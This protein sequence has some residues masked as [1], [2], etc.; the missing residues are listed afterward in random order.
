MA[1]RSASCD[2][3][4]PP[5]APSVR[6][7]VRS[8]AVDSFAE[9]RADGTLFRALVPGDV[10]ELVG[11]MLQAPRWMLFGLDC[12]TNSETAL[13]FDLGGAEQCWR[14]IGSPG[15]RLCA[16]TTHCGEVVACAEAFDSLLLYRFNDRGDAFGSFAYDVPVEW[17][18]DLC[19]VGNT[20]MA[21]CPSDEERSIGKFTADYKL[22]S[23]TKD[24]R[25]GVFT[26][27]VFEADN[28]LVV[29]GG[30]TASPNHNTRL[31]MRY[32][33]L[34][35]RWSM[36]PDMNHARSQFGC[37]TCTDR[38]TLYAVAG[39][40]ETD[41]TIKHSPA[42]ERLDLRTTAWQQ[43]APLHWAYGMIHMCQF[44]EHT[45]AAFCV[46]GGPAKRAR[47]Y[48]SRADRWRVE[49]RWGLRWS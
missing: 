22:V 35:D 21:V 27:N 20:L 28:G 40:T 3:E 31:A 42:T 26:A 1:K 25:E 4:N 2:T 17:I 11:H 47:A 43:L 37:L 46:A 29:A 32:D 49:T 16:A 13:L 45:I 36:L 34:A 30:L 14:E 18:S 5:A 8:S 24:P 6:P 12:S 44:D 19:S 41:T 39:T 33:A 7:S 15:S 9:A 10:I 38:Q 23:V 48:D